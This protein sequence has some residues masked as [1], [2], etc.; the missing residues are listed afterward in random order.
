MGN[1][2]YTSKFPKTMSDG[3]IES[4]VESFDI[5]SNGYLAVGG[6]IT[7]LTTKYSLASVFNNGGVELWSKY[8]DRSTP[9]YTIKFNPAGDKIVVFH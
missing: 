6:N 2:C 8:F 5:G 3:I 1:E 9:I 7:P 4:I